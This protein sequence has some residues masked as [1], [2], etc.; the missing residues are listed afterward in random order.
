MFNQLAAKALIGF[1][2]KQAFLAIVIFAKRNIAY[3][4]DSASRLEKGSV[5]VLQHNQS[6]FRF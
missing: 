5:Y 1:N 3:G 2:K 6:G 4:N